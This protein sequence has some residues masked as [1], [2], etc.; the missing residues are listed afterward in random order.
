MSRRLLWVTLPL[1]ACACGGAQ[2]SNVG[3]FPPR[4][5]GCAV[6]LMHEAPTEPTT[7]I[8]PVHASC[9]ADVSQADCLRTLED[10][11]C[12]LGGDLVWG[13]ADQPR[14]WGDRNMWEGRAAH[15]GSPPQPS[16]Q[17]E[18]QSPMVSPR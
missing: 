12:K 14:V 17:T 18:R 13:V 4:P 11:V 10:Q 3:G 15:T 2:P 9:A 7:N 5:E 8:G 16:L 6:K 1:L